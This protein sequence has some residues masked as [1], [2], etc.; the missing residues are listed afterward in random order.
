MSIFA[1]KFAQT[2]VAVAVAATFL[3]V[4]EPLSAD[5]GQTTTSGVPSI[6]QPRDTHQ[7]TVWLFPDGLTPD[8]RGGVLPEVWSGAPNRITIRSDGRE[9][10]SGKPAV[11][12]WGR[13][14]VPSAP[15]KKLA[16]NFEATMT[17]GEK[18]YSFDLRVRLGMG[19]IHSLEPLTWERC[20]TVTWYY[21][22]NTEPRNSTGSLIREFRKVLPRI[23][24]ATG[25]KFVAVDNRGDAKLVVTWNSWGRPP[26]MPAANVTYVA[27][28]EYFKESTLTLNSKTDWALGRDRLPRTAMLEHELAHVV[29]VGHV[30]IPSSLMYPMGN[31]AKTLSTTELR[32][33][34]DIYQPAQCNTP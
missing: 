13:A 34:S 30:D 12:A 15:F 14:E 9:V 5:A 2:W 32:S 1:I 31:T 22:E 18:S 6:E 20:S 29:G 8:E 24:K 16:G 33:I 27:G 10:W 26:L 28:G 19:W 11:T 17:K 7:P 21:D 23:S 4:A 25:I 3:V